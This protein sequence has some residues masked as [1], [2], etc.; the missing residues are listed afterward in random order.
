M[1]RL[2]VTS[3]VY[4]SWMY[5]VSGLVFKREAYPPEK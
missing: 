1:P 5:A 2:S 3:L 4:G